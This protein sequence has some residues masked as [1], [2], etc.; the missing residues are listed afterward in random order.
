MNYTNKNFSMLPRALMALFLAFSA[1]AVA[2][3]HAE[4]ESH[5]EAYQQALAI[6]EAGQSRLLAEI[7]RI[8][9]GA[10]AHF[11]FLQYEHVEVLRHA[12]ALRHPPS[13]LNTQQRSKLTNQADQVLLVAEA[14]EFPIADFLR[15]HALLDSAVSNTIDITSLASSEVDET[16][17]ITL[18][19]LQ[20][21]A[22]AFQAKPE[23]ANLQALT[24]AFDA[25]MTHAPSAAAPWYAELAVQQ[26]RITANVTAAANAKAE[27]QTASLT[28]EAKLLAQLY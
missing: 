27:V 15:S 25:A 21:A 4:G 19:E 5:N 22:R 10:V 2:P 13:T 12:R 6:V 8:E 9:S 26:H 14:L 11:D 7:H 1:I 18:Q 20:N 16:M 17:K 24:T 3:A 28:H 23:V